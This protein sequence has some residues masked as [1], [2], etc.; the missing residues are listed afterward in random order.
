ME[1]LERERA[2]SRPANLLSSP[3]RRSLLTDARKPAYIDLDAPLPF[4]ESMLDA[5][6]G[7]RGSALTSA[8]LDDVPVTSRSL[9]SSMRLPPRAAQSVRFTSPLQP[10]ASMPSRLSSIKPDLQPPPGPSASTLAASQQWRLTPFKEP[11]T[12]ASPSS[13]ALGM[14][15][16]SFMGGR[17]LRIG[18]A[19]PSSSLAA[20]LPPAE[21]SPRDL[22]AMSQRAPSPVAAALFPSAAT[23]SP[24][25]ASRTSSAAPSALQSMVTAAASLPLSPLR[26][27]QSFRSSRSPA[28]GAS[29][30][31]PSSP[32]SPSHKQQE[33]RAAEHERRVRAQQHSPH[34]AAFVRKLFVD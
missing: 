7:S 23:S 12:G 11:P 6:R 14:N 10:S 18:A 19:S 5:S 33:L 31:G 32:L 16:A 2:K 17:T 28:S 29:S 15:S 24:L 13:S 8:D 27:S 3:L 21:A 4:L 22:L 9:A 1:Q 26:A 20:Q 25:R 30:R 34:T